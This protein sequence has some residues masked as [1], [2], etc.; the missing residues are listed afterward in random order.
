M[1]FREYVIGFLQEHL[2]TCPSRKWL[3]M[4][5]PGCGMQRSFIALLQGHFAESLK[6]HPATAP[7]LLLLLYSALHV[8]FHF[9]KGARNITGLQLGVAGIVLVFYVY[10]I[11]THQIFH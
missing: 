10:K 2:L 8:K 9:P 5:C 1:A 4:D 7:M 6:L 3:H 11:F